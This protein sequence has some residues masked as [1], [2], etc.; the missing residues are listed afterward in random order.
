MNLKEP[1]LVEVGIVE[2]ALGIAAEDV[3]LVLETVGVEH[4][5]EAFEIADLNMEMENIMV[6]PTCEI[7]CLYL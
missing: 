1:C 4:L 7:V 6:C 2:V 3:H 5:V